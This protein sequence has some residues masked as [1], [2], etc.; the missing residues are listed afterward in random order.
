MRQ[1]SSPASKVE[2]WA[3]LFI[4]RRA[5][6][7]PLGGPVV[8]DVKKRMLGVSSGTVRVLS[9]A[10]HVTGGSDAG[11]EVWLLIVR[12]VMETSTLTFDAR[13]C[14]SGP[15]RRIGLDSGG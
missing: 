5:C 13:S 9:R 11:S 4:V 12:E 1:I 2:T 7:T 14:S 15:T 3:Y 6:R 8:P 10:Y